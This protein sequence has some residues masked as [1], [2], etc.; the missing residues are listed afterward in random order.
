M[1][2]K[3]FATHHFEKD[4]YDYYEINDPEKYVKHYEKL[5]WAHCREGFL[6]DLKAKEYYLKQKLKDRADGDRK[7]K[8][9]R[10]NGIC[11][12][13]ELNFCQDDE[14]LHCHGCLD[15]MCFD[16]AGR[17]Q[18]FVYETR[19]HWRYYCPD[20]FDPTGKYSKCGVCKND[21]Y[22]YNLTKDMCYDCYEKK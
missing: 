8:Q 19:E 10:H 7:E 2:R 17:L 4:M 16:C 20:C 9:C 3:E 18:D 14:M 11:I 12:I 5:G 22:L 13:C 15:V 21:C 6:D 1:S